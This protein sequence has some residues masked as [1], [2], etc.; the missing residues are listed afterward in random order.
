MNFE[1]FVVV[2]FYSRQE[3]QENAKKEWRV[4]S[5][6]WRALSESLLRNVSSDLK[7]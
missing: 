3:A 4:A 2:K 7:A 5:N 1:P 6:W